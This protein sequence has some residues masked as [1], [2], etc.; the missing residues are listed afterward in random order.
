MS[1]P[2]DVAIAG[3]GL[4]GASLAKNLAESGVNVLV[5]EHERQFKDRIRGEMMFP[6]GHAEAHS[7]GVAESL[8]NAGSN[9]IHWVDTY[10]LTDKVDHRQVVPTTPQLLPCLACYHPAMQE[11]LLRAASAAGATVRRGAAVRRVQPGAAPSLVVEE[12]GR[13]ETISARMVV[14]ADGRSSVVR[15]SARFSLLRDPDVRMIAGV[16]LE[17]VPAADDT[18]DAIYNFGLGQLVVVA[19]QGGGRVRIYLC[20]H[21][22]TQ[23]RF[24]GTADL[25]RFIA[26]C[27]RTGAS[28]ALFGDAHQAGPLATF[29]CAHCW[30]DHPYR[31]GVALLGDAA[32][33]SDPTQGQGLSL[34]LR[35]ARVLR[36]HLLSS[37]DWDAAAHAYAA[38]HDGYAGRLHTFNQW[39]TELYLTTG[40][41]ADARRTRVMPLIAEDPSRQPDSIFSGPD[42][43]ADEA[44]RKRYFGED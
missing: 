7:L 18:A 43:P 11:S 12:N 13:V 16:L 22:G 15:S 41:D 38:E 42:F 27:K 32:A 23:A 20:Y 6:W 5:I 39:I 10:V 37:S 44:A 9:E 34:T 4:G 31:D 24:Q 36:D 35:D 3:G 2:Y 25:A 26:G 30:V 29:S 8:S 17:N 14:G 28:D 40:P 19:P 21:H 33:A 1:T